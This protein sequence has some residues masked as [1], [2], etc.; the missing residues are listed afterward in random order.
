MPAGYSTPG[1]VIGTAFELNFVTGYDFDVVLPHF[2]GYDGQHYLGSF[3][4]LHTEHGTG[5]YFY[6]GA[7]HFD[8]FFFRQS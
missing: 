6:H 2:S 1:H 7:G 8:G 3:R 4:D 5:Q